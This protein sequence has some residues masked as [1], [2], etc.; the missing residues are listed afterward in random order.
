MVGHFDA[1]KKK[2][3]FFVT[4]AS[5]F[6]RVRECVSVFRG[7]EWPRVGIRGYLPPSLRGLLGVSKRALQR[8]TEAQESDQTERS[9]A[10]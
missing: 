3:W 4:C 5:G 9:A 6:C 7:L 1:G 2:G 10:L 8:K